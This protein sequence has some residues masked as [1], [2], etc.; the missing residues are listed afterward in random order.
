[1]KLGY[2]GPFGDSNFGD[3]AMLINDIL[4]I[5]EKNIIIYT[6]NIDNTK[7]ICS[8]YLKNFNIEYVG[9]DIEKPYINYSKEYKVEYN[10]Y[11]FVPMEIYKY[12]K[13]ITD[14]SLKVREIDKLV[15]I[16]GGYF[17]HLWNAK[18]RQYKLLAIIATILKANEYNKEI[19]FLGNTY[20]PFLES[21]EMF[22]LFFSYL[23]NTVFA[24]RDNIFSPIWFK[25][26]SDSELYL[27]PDDLYFLN[28]MFKP[29]NYEKKNNYIIL[30]VY[31]SIK[32]LEDDIEIYKFFVKKIKDKYDLDV[33]FFPF[34]IQYGGEKQGKYL[35]SKIEELEYFSIH[36]NKFV[37]IE[38]T[39]GIV[40]NAT[41]ILCNRYHLFVF[42]IANNVPAI[43]ILK[44]V[45]ENK[46]YYY[47]KSKGVLD[48][49]F[50]NQ[51]YEEELF[52]SLSVSDCFNDVINNLENI[53]DNQ[54]KLFNKQKKENEKMMLRRRNEFLE[55]IK[56]Q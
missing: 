30:E 39:L 5:G 32:E 28:K 25:D 34:D 16:G 44:N 45:L 10:T 33:I 51:Y 40:K 42:A 53:V 8:Q 48:Q 23:N 9:I 24:T 54:N 4:D 37:K 50:K 3:Y 1:M 41:L 35:Y 55:M 6:Y 7:S 52:L 56:N 21:E 22:K 15:V 47:T 49:V 26:I 29:I 31:Y 17:N 43:Q 36:N 20:G 11:S 12:I 27:L 13:N 46:T 38:D 18:H 14:L 19:F 2:I